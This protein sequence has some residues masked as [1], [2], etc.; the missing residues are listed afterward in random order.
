[1]KYVHTKKRKRQNKSMFNN[2]ILEP[3]KHID[4]KSHV[5]GRGKSR[6]KKPKERINS[7]G[8]N[9]SSEEKDEQNVKVQPL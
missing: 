4:H 3:H 8:G 1:M 7:R 6:K 5:K 9:T 2:K